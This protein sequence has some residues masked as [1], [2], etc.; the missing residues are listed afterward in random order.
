MRC[1]LISV[2]VWPCTAIITDLI[3]IPLAALA[4]DIDIGLAAS[5]VTAPVCW[6]YGIVL[7]FRGFILHGKEG[8]GWAIAIAVATL[9]AW[10]LLMGVMTLFLFPLGRISA[11]F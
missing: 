8:G 11:D 3:A 10:L 1:F 5:N 6:I 2:A 4:G 7:W 9:P